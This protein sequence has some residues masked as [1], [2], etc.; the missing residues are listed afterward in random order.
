MSRLCSINIM[1][2]DYP[3]EYV[4]LTEQDVWGLHLHDSRSIQIHEGLTGY[5]ERS[6]ILHETIHAILFEAG[7]HGMITKKLEEA[8]CRSVENGLMRSGLIKDQ[9]TQKSPNP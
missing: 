4:D 6:T 7:I 3:I 1:G 9:F 5:D 2:Q 8:I